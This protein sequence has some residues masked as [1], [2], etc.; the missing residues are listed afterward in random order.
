[1]LPFQHALSEY[2]ASEHTSSEHDETI[3]ETCEKQN[4]EFRGSQTFSERLHY[5]HHQSSILATNLNWN[6][7]ASLNK[8][9]TQFLALL[10]S[11]L[12]VSMCN[13]KLCSQ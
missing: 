9:T 10:I 11:Q 1:M 2:A 4:K 5:G 13:S 3:R 12:T 8:K 7:R 6:R